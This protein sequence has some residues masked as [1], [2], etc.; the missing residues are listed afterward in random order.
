[1]E[2]QLAIQPNL[3]FIHPDKLLTSDFATAVDDQKFWIH[4]LD[5]SADPVASWWRKA[6]DFIGGDAHISGG[7]CD[8]LPHE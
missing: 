7:N 1:M 5:R 6:D 2:H 4:D 8:R 3:L